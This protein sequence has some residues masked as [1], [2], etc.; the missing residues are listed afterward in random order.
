MSTLGRS[1][2]IVALR[3]AAHLLREPGRAVHDGRPAA[4]P[5]GWPWA[6]RPI[7]P[8]RRCMWTPRASLCLG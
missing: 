7:R 1:E 3:N 6:P 4:T 8:L 5:S 2:I